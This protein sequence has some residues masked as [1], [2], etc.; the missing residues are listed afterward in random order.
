M[1]GHHNK[2]CVSARDDEVQSGEFGSGMFYPVRVYVPFH[3]VD[4]HQRFLP[5]K[6][7]PDSRLYADGKRSHQPGPAGHGDEADLLRFSLRFFE[8]VIKVHGPEVA[9]LG[10]HDQKIGGFFRCLPHIEAVHR[11]QVD[12]E[13][14]LL[15][16]RGLQLL[17]ALV[18]V[19]DNDEVADH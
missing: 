13:V 9:G 15:L 17:P 18:F 8:R 10:V 7:Q 2:F 5:P 11:D 19:S 1:P 16:Q 14:R 4:A 12:R 3:M 6:S